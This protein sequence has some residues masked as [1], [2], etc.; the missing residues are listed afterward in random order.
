[1]RR[2]LKEDV[3]WITN[4]FETD[5]QHIYLSLY[6]IENDGD[7]I[8]VDTGPHY[9]EKEVHDEIYEITG[10]DFVD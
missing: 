9:F 10:A 1:M 7:Y 4:C 2:K 6:L 5:C 8:L 3:H